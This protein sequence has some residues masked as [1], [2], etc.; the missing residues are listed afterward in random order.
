MGLWFELALFI[1]YYLH[2]VAL[3]IFYLE[4]L[5]FWSDFHFGRSIEKSSHGR[6]Y[7][8]G[9][10]KTRFV[11]CTRTDLHRGTIAEFS[12]TECDGLKLQ[13]W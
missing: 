10:T 12:L 2:G 11:S 8:C 6:G 1:C 13:G 4:R 7:I 9:I 3:N 5:S